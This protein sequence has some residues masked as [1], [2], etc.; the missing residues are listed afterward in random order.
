M[1]GHNNKLKHSQLKKIIDL[2]WTHL[3]EEIE[4]LGR[5]EYRELGFY[6]T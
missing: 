1:D 3:Q 2:D 5:Q 4:V 6:R